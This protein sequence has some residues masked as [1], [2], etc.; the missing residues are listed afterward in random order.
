MCVAV[1]GGGVFGEEVIFSFSEFGRGGYRFG[2]IGNISLF[3]SLEERVSFWAK[4]LFPFSPL[5]G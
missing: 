1:G 2:G 3:V 5:F 4:R